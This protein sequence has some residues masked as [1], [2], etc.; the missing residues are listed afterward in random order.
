MEIMDKVSVFGLAMLTPRLPLIVLIC[1]G[2]SS[3]VDYAPA[4]VSVAKIDRDFADRKLP[5]QTR[6]WTIPDLILLSKKRQAGREQAAAQYATA[7][8]ALITAGGSVNPAVSLVPGINTSAASGT[9]SGTPSASFDLLFETAH[10]KDLR[11]L[12]AQQQLL[13]AG[14]TQQDTEWQLDAAVRHAGWNLAFAQ[15]R[16]ALLTQALAAQEKVLGLAKHQLEAGLIAPTD[17]QSQE[18]AWRKARLDLADAE[19]AALDARAQLAEA[20]GLPLQALVR[21]KLNLAAEPP[22]QRTSSQAIARVRQAALVHRP[23]VAMGLADYAAAEADLALEVAK[24]YP[25]IKVSPGYQWDQGSN[26][27]QLGLGF[28]LPLFNQNQGP[29][30]EASARRREAQSRLEMLQAKISAEVDRA[31]PALQQAWKT[32][33]V[34]RDL[35]KTQGEKKTTALRRAQ[36]GQGE[37]MDTLLAEADLISA[38]LVLVDRA[39]KWA[40][41]LEAL[42]ALTRPP[43]GATAHVAAEQNSK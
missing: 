25:D 15:E 34:A 4:P 35:L 21:A 40:Q 20:V 43:L 1:L 3:C 42:E 19:A 27:W 10:K 37:P 30:A 12:K 41:Q 39:S 18:L 8:A 28:D 38:Q 7:E 13:K 6:A 31:V 22:A 11:L 23:D 24:Q 16:Q 17:V 26:K 36:A 32:Y 14:F 33:Q 29:I 2:C 5:A 9:P